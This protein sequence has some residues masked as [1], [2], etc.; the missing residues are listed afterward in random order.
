MHRQSRRREF[1]VRT[2]A[3]LPLAG[4]ALGTP[5]VDA[6][7]SAWEFD[8]R[9]YVPLDKKPRIAAIFSEFRFRSHAFNILENVLGNRI[10]RGVRRKPIV[11]VVALYADQFPDNDLARE[12]SRKF[13]IPLYGS[14]EEALC[15]GG[16]RL[17]VDGVLAIVE[18]GE[19]P[20]NERGQKLY[21]RKEFFDRSVAVMRQANHF[22]PY[23]NDKHLSHDACEG[24]DMYATARRH[25][26]PLMA[27]SSVPLAARRPA[28]DLP[29]L[30][31]FRDAVAIHGGGVEVYDIHAL[32]LLQSFVEERTGNETGIESVQF[33]EG[34][35]LRAAIAAPEWPR[36]LIDAALKA[37]LG[38]APKDYW[39]PIEGD[40]A[41]SPPHAI[42]I[43]YRDGLRATVLK[44]GQNANRWNFACRLADEQTIRATALY[45]G[46]WGNRNLFAALANAIQ[47]FFVVREAPYS[48]VRTVLAGA[49]L[50]AAMSS[51]Q[52]GGVPITSPYLGLGYS[53][54][55]VAPFREDG[56][57][58]RVITKKNEEPKFFMY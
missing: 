50:D 26:I 21:P 33:L 13:E 57:S 43:R 56:A 34:D 53:P 32:E 51:R 49:A 40:S 9:W 22:V 19:Y 54:R 6:A 16:S 39:A 10:F 37:E 42:A 41:A 1:L 7:E 35:Q 45:N 36:K 29:H 58:W 15:R 12:I 2:A 5:R 48:V 11:D 23:F 30:P 27:G 20:T 4:L 18:H 28:I 46:P 25:A 24:A 52:F 38:E 14:I 44:V 17:D 47:R 31:V 3:A 55:N 8:D